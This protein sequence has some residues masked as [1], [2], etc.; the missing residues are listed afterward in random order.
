MGVV[1]AP[2]TRSGEGPGGSEGLG[3]TLPLP[4]PA[5][6]PACGERPACFSLPCPHHA[7]PCPL[8]AFS[9]WWFGEECTKAT[10]VFTNTGTH[11]PQLPEGASW[12]VEQSQPSPKPQKAMSTGS[13][14]LNSAWRPQGPWASRQAPKGSFFQLRPCHPDPSTSSISFHCPGSAAWLPLPPP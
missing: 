14:H 13:V 6:C 8:P 10:V 12:A 4:A 9:S 1:S 5:S 7:G 2:A 3:L 11:C